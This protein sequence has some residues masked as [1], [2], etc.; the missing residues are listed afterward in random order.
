[1]HVVVVDHIVPAEAREDNAVVAAT[2][3]EK[4]QEEAEE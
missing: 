2:I 1:M 4:E 3:T